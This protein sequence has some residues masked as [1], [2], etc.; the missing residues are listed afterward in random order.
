LCPSWRKL[1]FVG[2]ASKLKTKEVRA[3]GGEL[4]PESF[5]CFPL[6]LSVLADACFATEDSDDVGAPK[7]VKLFK[8]Y[9]S[10]DFDDAEEAKPTAELV[11]L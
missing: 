8:N 11:R 7:T 1:N 3:K 9:T 2:S 10:L 4:S 5:L 6:V